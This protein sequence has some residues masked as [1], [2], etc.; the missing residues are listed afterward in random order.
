MSATALAEATTRHLEQ[1]TAALLRRLERHEAY[2]LIVSP[3]TDLALVLAVVRNLLL[4]T[5]HYGDSVTQAAFTALG[6]FP[7]ARPSLLR[8]LLDQ[9]ADEVGHPEMAL[10]D[11][12]KMGGDGAAARAARA[13]PAA[14]AVAATCRLLAEQESPFAD[15]GFVSLLEFTTP[16]LSERVGAVLRDR[17]AGNSSQF[18]PL[19]ATED[20]EHAR[21]IRDSVAALVGA[22]P[23]AA[24]A[25]EYGFDCFAHVYP[26]PVWTEAL[27]QARLETGPNPKEGP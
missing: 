1:R 20:H 4:R 23:E 8:P 16:V 26:V 13:S 25:I 27:A 6:R 19:H 11:Y 10:R 18:I 9:V 15:L 2:R 7:K 12:V 17:R 3:Q 14:F 22:F 24:A 21:V 5:Y